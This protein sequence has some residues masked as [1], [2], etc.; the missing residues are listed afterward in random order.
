MIAR[1]IVPK[2]QLK[3]FQPPPVSELNDYKQELNEAAE[4]FVLRQ[5]IKKINLELLEGFDFLDLS[6]Q[7][8]RDQMKLHLNLSKMIVAKALE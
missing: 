5:Q 4:D 7:E 8:V 1:M 2:R 3:Q 6:T